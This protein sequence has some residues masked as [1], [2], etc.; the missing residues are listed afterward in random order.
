MMIGMMAIIAVLITLFI[1]LQCRAVS[2]EEVLYAEVRLV[3]DMVSDK[4]QVITAGT[5]GVVVDDRLP[6]DGYLI[7]VPL[8]DPTLVGDFRYDTVAANREDFTIVSSGP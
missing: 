6:C 4:G 7:E 3:K 5:V 2:R 1:Y 8:F